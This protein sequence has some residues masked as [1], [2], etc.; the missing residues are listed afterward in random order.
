MLQHLAGLFKYLLKSKRPEGRKYQHQGDQE[1]E[2]TDAVDDEC[3]LAGGSSRWLLEPERDQQV[4]AEADE[5]PA[6]E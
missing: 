4:R 6:D 2:I 1:A 3:L 5:F